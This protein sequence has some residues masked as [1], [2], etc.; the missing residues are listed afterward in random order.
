M[1]DNCAVSEQ[2]TVVEAALT[3]DLDLAFTAFLNDPL[4]TLDA[5]TARKLFDEM[6]EKEDGIVTDSPF[7]MEIE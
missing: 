7:D 4:V 6:V 2:E 3:R 5:A 1:P